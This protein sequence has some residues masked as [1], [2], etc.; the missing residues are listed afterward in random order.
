MSSS[1]FSDALERDA[2]EQI[3]ERGYPVTHWGQGAATSLSKLLLQ[4]A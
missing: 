2:V 3:T 4:A 1:E